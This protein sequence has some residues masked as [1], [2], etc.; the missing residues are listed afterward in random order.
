MLRGTDAVG[1]SWDAG[2]V[3]EDL[4]YV[5]EG[6][7]YAVVNGLPVICL[8]SF[9]GSMGRQNAVFEAGDA[10]GLSWSPIQLDYEVPWMQTRL[11]GLCELDGRLCMMG[12]GRDP[13]GAAEHPIRLM[14]KDN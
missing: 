14:L 6:L 11:R 4:G 2:T 13:L 3:L 1:S 12:I 5:F 9:D 7:D 8:T 10:A